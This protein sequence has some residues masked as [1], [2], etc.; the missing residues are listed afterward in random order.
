[1]KTKIL[2]R[3]SIL[4][5]QWICFGVCLIAILSIVSGCNRATYRNW[6]DRDAY[7]LL[8]SR[9]F[10]NRWVIPNRTV[11]PDATSRLADDNCPDCGPLPPDDPA[12][13][14]YMTFPYRTRRPIDYWAKRGV[15]PSVDSEQWL[16]YLPA[17]DE[18][19]I[20]VDK[21]TAVELALIHNREFQTRVEQLH[22]A[23]IGLSANHFE[24]DANWNAGSNSNFN[25]TA[26]GLAA[27]R[28]VGNNNQIGWSRNLA[29]GG[30]F[31]T[32]IINSFTWQLGGGPNTNFGTGGLLFQLTQP[33]LR[34]AFRHVRTESL[35][36]AERSLLYSVRDFA[37]FRRQFYF[38][39][40]Q[41]YLNLVS[42]SQSV[43]IDEENLRNL[44]LNLAEHNL[45]F[46]QGA[47]SPIQVDQVA[48]QFQS[49]KLS[50]ISSRQSQETA[51]DQFK[52]LLGLPAKVELDI[53]Q[54]I[55]EPF[56]LNAPELTK[57]QDEAEALNGELV[58][59]LPPEEADDAF[60]DEVYQRI[61]EYSERLEKLK[62]MVDKEYQQWSDSLATDDEGFDNPERE[63]REQ[64][65]ILAE[66]NKTFLDEL[67][68]QIKTNRELIAKPIEELEL[69]T[70]RPR[71]ET[72]D[73]QPVENEQDPDPT[74]QDETDPVSPQV[75]KWQKLQLL[76]AQR[77]G[78]KDRINTLFVMQAQIR[79][80]S[81]EIKPFQITEQRAVK[82]A[83]NNR[84]DLMNSRAQVVDAYRGV[85]IAADSLQ[86]DLSVSASANLRTDPTVDNA[87]RLDSEHNQ[88]QL[89]VSFDGPVN[90]FGERNQYRSAQIAYQQQ[91]RSY[92]QTEDGIVNRVRL[93]LRQLQANRYNFLISRQQLI[94]AT[95]QLDQAQ[96]NLRT[97][98][99]GD[100]SLTQDVLRALQTLRDAK[101]GLISSWISYEISRISL[102]VDLEL[103]Q[104]DERGAWV[105]E[106]ISFSDSDDQFDESSTG[107]DPDDDDENP[108]DDLAPRPEVSSNN[109]FSDDSNPRQS[110]QGNGSSTAKPER[111]TKS[112]N[113]PPSE[114]A[115]L[116]IDSLGR[117]IVGRGSLL[118]TR[119]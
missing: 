2:I 22:L 110:A 15:L 50:L 19:K 118:S 35:T 72:D 20:K 66:R 89:G 26:D 90:R 77:G 100:S 33:L 41:Q 30:Q 9:Q 111:A 5:I 46:G 40:V 51:L 3:S 6:A 78:L 68:E 119:Q 53:D 4:G 32:N 14:C 36:Q 8:G 52:F 84:L 113:S 31:L 18:G 117:N 94:T 115:R 25:A 105:N 91:R 79:L 87:F 109:G 55:L 29:S 75:E 108:I 99:A 7:R 12:A 107:S 61:K 70:S 21:Q 76:I 74:N 92:M 38:D 102:F 98:T 56:Q 44:E 97:A 60:L 81:I 37:R 17:D 73:G 83:L 13:E 88:Y 34:G 48:Q 24:F 58:K 11:E 82:I 104:L 106:D 116:G 62:L 93:N 59:Y 65:R 1:M 49:G 96:F 23:A 54:S 64:Q 63:D 27:V 85:E 69:G 101:T 45:L 80:F 47:V 28:D 71:P 112:T 57:L 43:S 42:Q 10:D 114:L 86:S 95:R 67:D 16:Q 103:L 39:I